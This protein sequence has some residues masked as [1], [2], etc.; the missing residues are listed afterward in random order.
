MKEALQE[1][2]VEVIAAVQAAAGKA[3]E[4]A[5]TQLPQVAQEYVV[6][7][8]VKTA[9]FTSLFL[10]VGIA[11]ICLAVWAYKNP[12]NTSPY[13]IDKG[14]NRSESNRMV[15]FFG[16]SLGGLIIIMSFLAFDYLVWFAPKVWLIKE[17]SNLVK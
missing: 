1:K 7:G 15:M 3:G 5:L 10:V 12:W 6:Y 14:K 16:G 13:S 17:L 11:A 8:R 4:F 2:L 9:V